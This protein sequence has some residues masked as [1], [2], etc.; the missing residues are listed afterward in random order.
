[1]DPLDQILIV[2][3]TGTRRAQT[4]VVGMRD[5]GDLR[6]RTLLKHFDSSD[7]IRTSDGLDTM[8]GGDWYSLSGCTVSRPRSLRRELVMSM[9]LFF[10]SPQPCF[11]GGDESTPLPVKWTADNGPP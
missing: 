8:N 7:R 5:G 10:R 6:G 2:G 9:D 3:R 1:V 11:L 4:V